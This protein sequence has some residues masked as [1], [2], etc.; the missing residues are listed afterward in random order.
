MVSPFRV[1]ALPDSFPD[2][3]F[4][5]DSRPVTERELSG[6]P[7]L[8]RET[9]ASFVPVSAPL[10]REGAATAL[11]RLTLAPASSLRPESLWL[12]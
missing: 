9:R 2:V 8:D 3:R 7:S 1:T 4:L 12:G 6:V 5:C 10:L 11:R